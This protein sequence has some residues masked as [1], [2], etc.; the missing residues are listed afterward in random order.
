MLKDVFQ[1]SCPCCGK[2]IEVD[3]R[4]GRARAVNPEEKKGGG[5]LDKLLHAH[6]RDGDRLS[7][8]FDSAKEQQ[9]KQQE[10][11]QQALEQAKEA[12]KKDKDKKPPNPFD[13]D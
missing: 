13:L 5:D 12:A 8:V 11:L 1:F 9:R 2:P 10:H 6:K 4:S 3:T 7:D